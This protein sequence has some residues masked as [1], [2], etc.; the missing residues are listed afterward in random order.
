MLDA[1]LHLGPRK[2]GVQGKK[3]LSLFGEVR[4]IDRGPVR[5]DFE[6]VRGQE[7]AAIFVLQDA[8]AAYNPVEI[9]AYN[10]NAAVL[11]CAIRILLQSAAALRT[12][13]CRDF[14]RGA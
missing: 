8:D 2:A 6:D 7:R 1:I 14:V 5:A 12:V 11:A 10:F 9:A 3:P 13:N 4:L